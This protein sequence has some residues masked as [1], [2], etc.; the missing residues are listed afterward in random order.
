MGFGE[1]IRTCYRGFATFR[2][3]AARAEY[4]WFQLF[5]SL[6][7]IVAAAGAIALWF[8]AF[9]DGASPA[10]DPAID[11]GSVHLAPLTL[12]WGIVLAFV[13]AVGVPVLAVT[14]RRLHDLGMSAW[15]LLLAPV[16]L[17]IVLHV[18]ALLR[19]NEGANRFGP[20]PRIV[21]AVRAAP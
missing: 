12:A 13:V 19:G 15:W 8:S 17:S 1:A 7:W 9:P 2:G 4:W 14:A 10:D 18:L 16:G 21:H 3:R 5:A 20:D 6:V 11:P